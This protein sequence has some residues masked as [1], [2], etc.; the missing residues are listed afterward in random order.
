[1]KYIICGTPITKKNSSRIILVRGK[2]RIIPSKQFVAYE[3]AALYQLMSVRPR[4]AVDHPVNVKCVYYMPTNRRVDLTNL[5][6]AT[7][8][9]LVDAR[10]LADD[11]AKIVVGHDGSRVEYRATEPRVEIEITEEQK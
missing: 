7:M 2:P 6:A 3:K 11:N 4:T 1:V 5:L 10:I 8:D 9:I